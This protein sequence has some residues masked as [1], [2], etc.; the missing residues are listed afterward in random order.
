MQEAGLRVRTKFRRE[1][2]EKKSADVV[3]TFVV[4]N[5][6]IRCRG[7]KNNDF[8]WYAIGSNAGGRVFQEMVDEFNATHDHIYVDAVYTGNYG[9]TAQKVTASLAA[10]TLPTGGLIPATPLFTGRSGNYLIDEYLRGG[11]R[12]WIW[13][14]FMMSLELQQI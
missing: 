3:A 5:R 2:N 4:V 13:K 6:R 14:T 7:S 8:F 11:R 1:P 10:D 12:D 9:E